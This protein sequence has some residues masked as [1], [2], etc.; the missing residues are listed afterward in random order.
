MKWGAVTYTF[1][2]GTVAAPTNIMDQGIDLSRYNQPAAA[3]IARAPSR[4]H[5]YFNGTPRISPRPFDRPPPRQSVLS[6]ANVL[7]NEP[8]GDQLGEKSP[9]ITR[10]YCIN[11]N[12]ITLDKRGGK[13]DTVCRCIKEVQADIFCGQEHKLDTTQSNVRTII[14]DTARQHW[15]RQRIVMGTTPIPF[16]KTYKPGGTMMVTTGALTSRIKKQVRDKWGRWVC[17]EY[18]GKTRIN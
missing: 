16:D 6:A 12:G 3:G 9:E 4:I 1:L 8:W 5:Q 10:V 13:F 17:Q 15:V 14:Y 7:D 18:Q 2:G 11:L